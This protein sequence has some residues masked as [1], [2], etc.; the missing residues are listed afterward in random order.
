MIP[1]FPL[2]YKFDDDECEDQIVDAD[3]NLVFSCHFDAFNNA[4]QSQD[5]LIDCCKVLNES[6]PKELA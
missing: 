2:S 4:F 1:K 5:F 3:N 6:L